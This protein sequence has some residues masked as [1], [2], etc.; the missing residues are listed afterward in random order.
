[1][2]SLIISSA[3]FY[4]TNVSFIKDFSQELS[5]H[6]YE[7]EWFKI[8]RWKVLDIFLLKRKITQM[9]ESNHTIK[10]WKKS[11]FS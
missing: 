7:G 2:S 4:V 1:M 10:T 3:C 11:V 9:I 8:V 6:L 5:K